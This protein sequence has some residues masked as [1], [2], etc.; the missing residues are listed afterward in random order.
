MFQL[1]NSL[2]MLKSLIYK[3]SFRIKKFYNYLF[4]FKTFDENELKDF[5]LLN[6][7]NKAYLHLDPQKIIEP[8]I[9]KENAYPLLHK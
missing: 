9:I 7:Q 8:N 3:I 2:N 1:H 5:L 4:A 6:E